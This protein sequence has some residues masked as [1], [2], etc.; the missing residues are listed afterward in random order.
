MRQGPDNTP[1]IRT[2]SCLS[3]VLASTLLAGVLVGCGPKTPHGAGQQP[4]TAPPKTPRPPEPPPLVVDVP[5]EA[6]EITTSVPRLMRFQ[7]RIPLN[8]GT[9]YDWII[10]NTPPVVSALDSGI[11]PPPPQSPPGAMSTATF[12]FQGASEGAGTIEFVLERPASGPPLRGLR[13]IV[14]VTPAKTSPTP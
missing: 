11:D 7:L 3:V 4:S 5:A 6:S 10:R 12:L 1:L 13:V 9:G 8:T 2:L 14:S